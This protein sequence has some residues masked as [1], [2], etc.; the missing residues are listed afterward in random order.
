MVGKGIGN[1]FEFHDITFVEAM[2]LISEKD[3]ITPKYATTDIL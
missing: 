3:G 2:K 1:S